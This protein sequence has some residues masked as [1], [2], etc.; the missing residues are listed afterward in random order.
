MVE[1][2]S[3]GGQIRR[4]R[5]HAGFTASKLAESTGLDVDALRSLED[6]GQ[7]F[8]AGTIFRIAEFL[9]VSPIAILEPD[10]LPGRLP[11]ATRKNGDGV[12][13]TTAWR[14]ASLAELHH[15]LRINGHLASIPARIGEAPQ[16]T[17]QT[18]QEHIDGLVQWANAQLEFPT[19]GANR[20]VDLA[21]AIESRLGVDV[22]VET[23][24]KGAPLGASITDSEFPFIL[25]NADQS[26]PRALFTLAH[27]LGHMLNQD[28]HRSH[29]DGHFGGSTDNERS[30]NA[31]A[32]AFLMPETDI[33]EIITKHGRDV[34]SLAYMLLQFSVSYET[35]IYRLHNLRH[36]NTHGRDQLKKAG[37]AGLIHALKDDDLSRTLIAALNTKLA[38]HPPSLLTKRCWSGVMDGTVSI[39]PLA[40]LL[41]EDPDDLLERI[42][43]A[44]PESTKA[45]NGDYSS[46]PDTDEAAL[47]AY[48]VDPTTLQRVEELTYS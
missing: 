33:Q 22:M 45:I 28:G 16:R 26:A 17:S 46:P 48:D 19:P 29:V 34:K 2:A 3:V 30:A 14:L 11:V 13:D 37:R 41:D 35:L 10:S 27:E 4:L 18:W 39:R 47:S 6:G 21:S 12:S 5:E 31:F 42:N 8:E 9:K 1:G 43:S 36:I 7:A 38:R 15:V 40:G 44:G 25:V 20:L 23:R 24:E 32:V